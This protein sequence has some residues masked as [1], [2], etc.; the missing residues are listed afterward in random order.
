[1][2]RDRG[3]ILVELDDLKRAENELTKLINKLK[4]DEQYIRN[5]YNRLQGWKGNSGN[6]IRSEMEGFFKA[7]TDRVHHL[8][9]QKAEL[10]KYR[11]GMEDLDKAIAFESY[12]PKY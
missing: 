2:L 8:E 3:K 7:L 5:Q 4:S 11:R 12:G 9:H 1:M 6:K 10:T